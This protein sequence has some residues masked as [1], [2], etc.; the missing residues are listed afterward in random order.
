MLQLA[1]HCAGR[2]C[3]ASCSSRVLSHSLHINMPCVESFLT[4]QHAVMLAHVDCS[5]I[6]VIGKLA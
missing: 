1:E 6:G 5:Y 3:D 2:G 4:H